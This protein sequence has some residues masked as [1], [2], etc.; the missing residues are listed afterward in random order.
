MTFFSSEN[1][2]TPAGFHAWPRG[3]RASVALLG[4]L[5]LA[6]SFHLG[7][8]WLRN[9]DLSHGLFTPFLF[10]LLLHEARTRGARRWLTP[11]WAPAILVAAT[12]LG[13]WLLL[14]LGGVYAAAVGWTHAL[15]NFLLGAAASALCAAVG[16]AGADARVRAL[17]LNWPAGVAAGLWIFSA[18]IPPGTYTAL[19]LELQLGVT[20][21]VLGALHM[22]GVPAVRNGNII[23]LANVAVGVEEACS[24]VRSLLSCVFAALFFSAAL[25]RR[26]ARRAV[27]LVLAPLLA[28]A[29]NIARSLSLTLLAHAGVEIAGA[30]HDLTGFAVLAL[31]AALLAALALVLERA[32]ANAGAPAAGRDPP[33]NGSAAGAAGDKSGKPPRSLLPA[34]LGVAGLLVGFFVFNTRAAPRSTVPPPDFATLLPAAPPGWEV[35]T[36]GDLYRFAPQ[37]QTSHLFQRTYGRATANGSDQFTVYLAYWPAGQTPVSLVASHTPDACWPGAGWTPQ[38]TATPRVELA[39]AGRGLAPA[40]HR[41]FT[42]EDFPQHVWYWHLYDGRVLHHDGLGSP[43]KLLRLALRYGFRRDG[44][45]L[46][47]RISSNRDWETLSQ[48]PLVR[49][50]TERLRVLGL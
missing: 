45:Q 49:E 27:L 43:L 36:S 30:W 28:L 9:P 15:V 20:H 35:A 22:L 10:L 47:V 11:G 42:Q 44:D 24:G 38:P 5:L 16:L 2:P 33:T 8:Q 25:V 39:V 14:A 50:I 4:A 21:V 41:F 23:E 3:Y 37:L 19:T 40:E 7:P 17:P 32:G 18:P 34:G 12:L 46:F 26:P 6:W 29:M 1:P 13:G 31:T 48:D